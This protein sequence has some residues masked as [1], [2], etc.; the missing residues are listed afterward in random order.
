MRRDP[1]CDLDEKE[2][3]Y[4]FLNGKRPR[5]MDEPDDRVD[6]AAASMF[7]FWC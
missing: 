5:Y 3:S 7:K 6:M 1:N 4:S 2:K